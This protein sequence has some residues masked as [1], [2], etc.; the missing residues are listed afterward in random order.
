MSWYV[1]A[2]PEAGRGKSAKQIKKIQDLFKEMEFEHKFQK[3]S[4]AGHATLLAQEAI[5]KGETKILTI[6]GDGTINETIQ[7]IIKTGKI[8]KIKFSYL[9]TGGGNDFNRYFNPKLKYRERIKAIKQNVTTRKID[10]C[11]I[12]DN[13]FIN[14]FGVGFDAMVVRN[15]DTIKHLNGLTRYMIGLI[16]S[17]IR[18]KTYDLDIE[19]D[20][21]NFKS[22]Y[23]LVSVGNG[24]FIGGGFK[25]NPYAEIDNGKMSI[26]LIKKINRK[27]LLRIL[28]S[29][30]VGKHIKHKEVSIFYSKKFKIK[31][32]G[33]YPSYVDGQN[34]TMKKN[35][36]FE[37]EIIDDK[38]NLVG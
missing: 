27:R 6:G 15:S 1:I 5:E 34:L 10:V 4:Y 23:T 17:T 37:I 26:C 13:Y 3:T 18:L 11:R 32:E 9:P 36:K 16:I 2:N 7:G 31:C 29:V 20:K 19:I 25:M 12:N 21:V 24:K 30:V 22:N 38:L 33:N 35:K 28:P 8:E 14:S